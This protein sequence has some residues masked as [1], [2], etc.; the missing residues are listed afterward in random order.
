MLELGNSR[1]TARIKP[2]ICSWVW[3]SLITRKT[4]F[5][6]D[7]GPRD[8]YWH[9]DWSDATTTMVPNRA[10][11]NAIICIIIPAQLRTWEASQ[12][13]RWK[14]SALF[15]GPNCTFM[16]GPSANFQTTTDFWPLLPG[17][18]SKGF[19][20]STHQSYLIKH[21]ANPQRVK[22]DTPAYA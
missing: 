19:G 11:R 7:Q 16:R 14:E 18:T 22:S 8:R 20:G 15:R 13:S 5:R 21:R 6:G 10:S 1:S 4:V 3:N 9:N 17:L 12:T 2:K